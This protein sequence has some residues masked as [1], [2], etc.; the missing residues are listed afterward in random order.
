MIMWFCKK[1]RCHLD[2]EWCDTC[3]QIVECD[4]MD[5]RKEVKSVSVFTDTGHEKWIDIEVKYC[6]TCG[7]GLSGEMKKK[8]IGL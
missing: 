4:H 6:E 8:R 2:I 5:S 1:C 7:K 3:G